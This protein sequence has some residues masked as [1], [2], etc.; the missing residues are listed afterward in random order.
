MANVRFMRVQWQCKFWLA[1]YLAGVLHKNTAAAASVTEPVT[2]QPTHCSDL[3]VSAAG[4]GRHVTTGSLKC[5]DCEE[6]VQRHR[7]RQHDTTTPQVR[8]IDRAQVDC[9]V[10]N[11]TCCHQLCLCSPLRL[12]TNITTHST[13]LSY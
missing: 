9:R 3:G 6:T 1:T 8:I 5:G 10:H 13:L 12:T 11:C 7:S 4:I 2:R